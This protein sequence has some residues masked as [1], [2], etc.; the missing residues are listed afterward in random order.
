M[1][2][3]FYLIFTNSYNHF[4]ASQCRVFFH[5]FFFFPLIFVRHFCL[6]PMQVHNCA[7]NYFYFCGGERRGGGVSLCWCY[8]LYSHVRG[9]FVIMY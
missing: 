7:H 5:P 3:T 9:K 4:L 6:G 2:V 8:V 1:M